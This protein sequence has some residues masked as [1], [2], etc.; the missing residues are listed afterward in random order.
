MAEYRSIPTT[1]GQLPAAA[2]PTNIPSGVYCARNTL[3]FGDTTAKAMFT[4]P[5]GAV[6]IDWI[7]NVTTAFNSDGTDLV[8]IGIS[9]TQEKFAADVDVGSTGLKTAGVVAAQIGAVQ[10]TAQAVTAI[11]AAGGSAPNAGAAVIMC[12]YFVP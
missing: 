12:R 4:I 6:I 8:D 10:G 1:N 2:M 9:G 3:A 7:I 11:Y 5:A